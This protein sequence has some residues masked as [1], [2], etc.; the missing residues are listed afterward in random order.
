MKVAIDGPA[1]SGK[2]T[3]A[4]ALAERL[5]LTLLD[6][7]AMYRSVTLACQER[8]VDLADD[9]AIAQVAREVR[10]EFENAEDGSQRV[11]LDGRDVSVEIRTPEVDAD[12]SRVSAVPAVRE[13]MVAEQ[14][15][16]GAEGDVVAEGR[17]IGTVVFPDAEVKVFLTADPEARAHRRALQRDV[18]DADAEQEILK[19]L[20]RRD[21]LD[22][23]RETAPLVAAEDA[24]RMDSSSMTVEEEVQVIQD[25]MEQ[26]RA[27]VAVEAGGVEES[28]GTEPAD[29]PSKEDEPVAQESD[30]PKRR[31]FFGR[32]KTAST[33]K[34]EK[35]EGET[36]ER[37]S[38][39]ERH[40]SEEYLEHGVRAF[41]IGARALLGAAIVV[42]GALSKPLWPWKV[43]HGER[44]WN[45]E[46]GQVVIMN[47]VSML[48]PVCLMVTE[49]AHGRRMRPIYK[50][51]FGEHKL[52]GWFF[53][54]IGGIPIERG[55]AD[56]KS[57]R[58]AQRALQRGEDVLIFPEGTRIYSDDQEVTV[59][60]GFALMAQLAK[61]P[62]LPVAIVGAR[63][64]AP[65]GN[66]PLRP[67]R[68]WISVGEPVTFDQVEGKGRKQ[69]AK[70][71][72]RI[73]M[74]RVYA[75]RDEL[76]AQHPGEM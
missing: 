17:D 8:G 10:I 65:G 59:H 37:M 62:V 7:G 42:W 21:E 53:T 66:K 76:R 69:R 74:E 11:L 64:G 48:D 3:V 4:H 40:E 55:T 39:F 54:R 71:V 9:E 38:P 31:F 43:E 35:K 44:L 20:L 26:A 2:S 33:E 67:G 41:P 51:E 56:I 75:L 6:T 58:R 23:S 25:L 52:V 29:T 14:R 73:A 12:V 18:A 32:K 72:E 47:H 1:G 27:K 16:L 46:G 5:G 15:R 28:A 50:S 70:E 61:A 13:A 45:A 49:W 60:G 19:D 68:V 34:E 36:Q 30:K 63:D 57:V 24:Y 22:S